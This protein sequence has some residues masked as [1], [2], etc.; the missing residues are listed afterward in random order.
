[1]LIYSKLDC[2]IVKLRTTY[3]LLFITKTN[4]K[5][6]YGNLRIQQP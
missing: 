1:M 3:R 4:S 5:H 6:Y 2:N